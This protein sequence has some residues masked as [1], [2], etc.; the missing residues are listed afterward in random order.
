MEFI[1]KIKKKEIEKEKS[2]IASL[3]SESEVESE[4]EESKKSGN[5]LTN[6]SKRK[7]FD[8]QRTKIVSEKTIES[9]YDE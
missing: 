2:F 7:S 3:K 6:L 9:Y 8:N 5:F 4:S 1:N